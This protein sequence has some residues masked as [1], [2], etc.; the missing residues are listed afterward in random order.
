MDSSSDNRNNQRNDNSR[1]S[2][3][4]KIKSG[5][6]KIFKEMGKNSNDHSY[7]LNITKLGEEYGN[8]KVV[9]EIQK[10]WA[11]KTNYINKKAKK[12][13]QLIREKYSN[14]R[15]PFHIILEKARLFK[16]KY[17]LS[18]DEFSQ[19]KRIYEQELIGIKSQEVAFPITNMMKI[20]GT[21]SGTIKP[22]ANNTLSDSD[23]KIMQD[24]IKI[25]VS[26][27]PLHAQVLLQ[28]I[29]Y[30]DCAFEA[31]SGEYRRELGHR[32]GESIHAVIAA[33]FIPKIQILEEHFLHSNIASIVKARY[34]DEPL[35]TKSDYQ[36]FYSLI[37]D[38]NDIICD[39]RSSIS[40]LYNRV[41]IQNQLW[42]NVINL[43]NGQY[44]GRNFRDF[45]GSVD[46]CK[47]NK[48]D[49]PDLVY[50]RYDG[51]ILKRLISAFS[52]RPT[53]VST[54][55][56]YNTPLVNINPYQQNI[57]SLV[58]SVSMINIKLPPV[59]NEEVSINLEDSLNSEQLFL[60]NNNI[61]ARNTS[62][63][64]SNGVLFFY[65]DRRTNVIYAQ[66][67]QPFNINK[68]P[69][70]VSG[71][72]RINDRPINFE[73]EIT[74]RKDIYRL[75][76]VVLAEINKNIADKNI[77]IGSSTIFMLHPDTNKDRFTE[78]FFIYDPIRVVDK[79]ISA[80]TA[81]Y[82]YRQPTRQIFRNHTDIE[83][84]SFEDMASRRGII[85]M[86]ELVDD[87]S[88]GEVS[89]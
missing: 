47:L 56:I 50:G 89:F 3:D 67:M 75:R 63:I 87:N 17:N 14:S 49:T 16:T 70:S 39:N 21:V 55:P 11:E 23:A 53:I 34:N 43:R 40:D 77:V 29:Q 27:R 31:L 69:T 74:I 45:V 38:P 66:D 1:D 83:N 73:T 10:V 85:F 6:A 82:V 33:M 24:I 4:D 18:E 81:T 84:M 8:M 62:I 19:F 51:T 60:E 57:K 42:E 64:Y 72:E 78:E 28:S 36:L 32:P 86:Y 61:T 65:I 88:K 20:L 79:L 48:Y 44:Y 41:Q 46:Q 22:I 58:T 9:E 35:T 54:L 30:S 25:H 26:S 80:S 5:V 59:L 37:N 15:L 2:N 12:F 13:A 68:L 7:K 76:S 71:F 52:F